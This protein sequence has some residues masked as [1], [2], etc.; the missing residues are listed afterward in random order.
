M[1]ASRYVPIL[2][3]YCEGLAAA[4]R[5]RGETGGNV[6]LLTTYAKTPTVKYIR[7]LASLGLDNGRS[8]DFHSVA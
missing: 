5:A 3:S 2:R 1:S 8:H 6:R 7:P 4:P